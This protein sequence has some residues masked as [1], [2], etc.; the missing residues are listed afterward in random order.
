[1]AVDTN[2]SILLVRHGATEETDAQRYSEYP[3]SAVKR[4]RPQPGYLLPGGCRRSSSPP[5]SRVQVSVRGKPPC[6]WR[7]NIW[8][9]TLFPN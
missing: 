3:R 6:L 4:T 5:S 7:P 8:N 9:C 2:S 1:M